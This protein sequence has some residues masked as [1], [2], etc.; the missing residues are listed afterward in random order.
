MRAVALAFVAGALW[1]GEA[2][3]Q[4]GNPLPVPPESKG[5]TTSSPSIY[6]RETVFKK[7]FE[8]EAERRRKLEDELQQLRGKV[9]AP[10][11]PPARPPEATS[12]DAAA[13][14]L[15][16]APVRIQA[17]VAVPP[18]R[19][20]RPAKKAAVQPAAMRGETSGGDQPLVFAVS[21]AALDEAVAGRET[22]VPL[23]SYVKARILTGVEANTLEAYPVLLQLDYAFVGPNRTR[24]DLSHCFMV[25]KAKA[26]LSTERVLGET[27]DLS[28]VRQNNEVVTRKAR[29]YVAGED[30]TFGVAGDLI[31]RQGQVLLA[32]VVASLARSAGEAV[33]QAQTT[34]SIVTGGVGGVASA[35][36]V[37]GD[38]L[39]YYGGRAVTEPA[40][41]IAN[42]YLEYA[43][44]LVPSIAVGSGRDVWIVLLDT[45][46]VPE[47]SADQEGEG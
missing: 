22:A 1:A 5:R 43:K 2:S 12:S 20:K 17:P 18:P 27:Q 19:A 47:L 7:K 6:E 30:S 25:A 39:A 13:A 44:Q 34:T 35:Q 4:Q 8:D 16:E 10:S 26:N 46:R 15:A 9:G 32:A 38:K 21:A 28:C 37:T 14:G 31:S 36:N 24:I 45:V 11:A 3:A 23:G 33:S 40:A 42:W 29:G 41:M